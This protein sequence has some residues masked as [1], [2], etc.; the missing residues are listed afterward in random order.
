MKITDTSAQ[1]VVLE[2][3][4]NTKFLATLV[5]LA[6]GLGSVAWIAAP[7]VSRW[8][9]AEESVS[10]ERLRFADVSRGDFVRDIS[11]QG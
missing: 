5:A 9:E 3:K 10:A 4:S 6:V 2:P 1:D 11:V 7:T 8:R